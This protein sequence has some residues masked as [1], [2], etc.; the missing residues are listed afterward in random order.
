M[1]HRPGVEG[2][3]L[4]CPWALFRCA[5]AF[6]LVTFGHFHSIQFYLRCHFF[7]SGFVVLLTLRTFF[8]SEG[9]RSMLLSVVTLFPAYDARTRIWG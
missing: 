9:L 2:D 3:S 7:Q 5:K 8:M 6:L 4:P 1:I